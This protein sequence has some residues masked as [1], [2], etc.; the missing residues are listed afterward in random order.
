MPTTNSNTESPSTSNNTEN[1]LNF[2]EGIDNDLTK[3]PLTNSGKK[4]AHADYVLE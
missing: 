3:N 4:Q 1:Y 2:L